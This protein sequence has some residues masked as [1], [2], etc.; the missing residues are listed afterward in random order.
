M[1]GRGHVVAP[2]RHGDGHAPGV[3]RAGLE[4]QPLQPL[5]GLV[6]W[7]GEA[8]EVGERG[9]AERRVT[10]PRGLRTGAARLARLAAAQLDHQGGGHVEEQRQVALVHP[11]LET[12]ARVGADVVPAAA[13]GDPHRVEQR[14]LEEA[15]L[16]RLVASR[17][18][19]ADDAAERLHAARVGDHAVLRRQRVGLAVQRGQLLALARHAPGEGVPAHLVDVED[20]QRPADAEG[21]EVGGVHQR[22]DRPQSGGDQP[23]LQP[24]RRRAVAQAADGAAEH[25]GA[26]AWVLDR[27]AERGGMGRGHVRLWPR[28]ESPQPRG[29]EVARDAVDAERVASV[30]RQ[31][32]LEDGVVEA[33]PPRVALAHRRVRRQVHDAGVVVAEAHLAGGE[34]HRL[35][36]HAADLAGLERDAG[37]G[38]EGAGQGGDAQHAGARVGRA[39]DDREFAPVAH[40]HAQR[41]QPV[42][43][44]V[45]HRLDHA[46]DAEGVEG[47][48]AVLDAL[49]LDADGGKR[50]GDAVERGVGVEV[51]AQPGEGELHLTRS[52]AAGTARARWSRGGRASAGRP[53]R[54]AEG[55]GCRA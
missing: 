36:P 15:L 38:D 8:A 20:V 2:G 45:R 49:D 27:P 10:P 31:L 55:R 51:R 9:E 47:R 46:R 44:G 33:G 52:R 39:A 4:A 22:V 29:R 54:R 18:L 50:V 42:G 24:L 43:V 53:R 28:L 34:H 1:D 25:P 40:V 11:A 7:H 26:G 6:R 32:H 41:A 5:A 17:A 23:V 14:A 19:A 13:A 35:G 30:G 21:E 16:R 12:L 3:A 37:A 48:A